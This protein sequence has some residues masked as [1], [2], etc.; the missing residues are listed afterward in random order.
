MRKLPLLLIAIGFVSLSS[1]SYFGEGEKSDFDK[2][3]ELIVM[4][5]IAYDMLLYAGDRTS[6]ILPA[7]QISQ[8]EF[9]IPFENKFAFLPDSLVNI[10]N[11]VFITNNL[12]KNYVVNVF[13]HNTKE[14]VFG[15]AV[16]DGGQ[17][18]IIPCRG[19][20]QSAKQYSINIQ[21]QPSPPILSNLMLWGGFVLL[22]GGVSLIIFK[23][24]KAHSEMDTPIVAEDKPMNT[25]SFQSIG[26]YLFYPTEQRL[27]FDKEQIVLT[28]KEAK[29]LSIFSAHLNQVVDREKLQKEVWEDEGVFVG[30]SLDMFI[31]K[32]RKKLD[33][34]EHLKLI[35]IHSKGYKLVSI[36]EEEVG[37]MS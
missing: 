27:E 18:N 20:L 3:K 11:N 19:R 14:V 2:S 32:L 29:L 15:Y 12:Y 37:K 10:I 7:K 9:I 13:E 22:I 6:R 36:S 26:K 1:M 4:R 35:N 17:K 31:S 34:D 21:F 24:K 30:R 25:T 33:K 23:A 28:V 5:K 16:L 8:N